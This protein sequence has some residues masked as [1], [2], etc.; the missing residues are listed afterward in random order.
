MD[1]LKSTNRNL[2]NFVTNERL[3]EDSP[4]PVNIKVYQKLQKQAKSVY[5]GLHAQLRCSAPP[6][7]H[8]CAV[9][10]DWTRYSSGLYLPSL[11]ILIG[12]P[13]YRRQLR[14]SIERESTP[15]AVAPQQTN[16]WDTYDVKL[17]AREWRGKLIEAASC[18]NIGIAAVSATATVLDPKK[19]NTENIWQKRET[20]KLQSKKAD[21]SHAQKVK[22][23]NRLSIPGFSRSNWKSSRSVSG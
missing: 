18:Y 4:I 19:T 3:I 17:R 15:Q 11:R 16:Q 22:S 14:C 13:S 7:S 8:Q 5:T 10:I 2:N 1:T 12:D 6:H 20:R 23:P 9:T 21:P